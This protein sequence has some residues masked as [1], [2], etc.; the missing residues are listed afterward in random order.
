MVTRTLCIAVVGA[1]GM[2]SAPRPVMAQSSTL[3]GSA[4][5]LALTMEA[6]QEE[7]FIQRR[8]SGALATVGGVLAAAGLVMAL[9]PPRCRLEGE[10]STS[11]SV[12]YFGAPGQD[13]WF[14]YDW[15]VRYSDAL[16]GGDCDI[17]FIYQRTW[18]DDD[19]WG[20]V[21]YGSDQSLL[22]EAARWRLPDHTVET[23]RT[24][25]YVGWAAVGAGGA[26]LW[27]GLSQVEVPFRVDLVPGGGFRAT[28]TWGW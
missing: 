28:R 11:D 7:T 8:R 13:D 10:T 9:Q 20:M 4:E 15:S 22:P 21:G 5:R 17:Q 27:Y 19:Q 3:R 6:E 18:H 25:N 23:N 26:L 1:I 16:K 14:G 2:A 12:T 24:L